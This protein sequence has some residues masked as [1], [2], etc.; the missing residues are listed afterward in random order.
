MADASL[1]TPA[2][3]SPVAPADG[4]PMTLTNVSLVSV[5]EI[6]PVTVADA[7]PMTVPIQSRDSRYQELVF[8]RHCWQSGSPLSSRGHLDNTLLLP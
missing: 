7:S 5:E 1:V 8:H 6:S 4:S 3:A 2:D